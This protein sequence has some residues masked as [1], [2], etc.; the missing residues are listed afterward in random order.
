MRAIAGS[1]ATPVCSII[2]AVNGGVPPTAPERTGSGRG[3]RRV[4]PDGARA[5]A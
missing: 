1:A 3:L 5:G 2:D 4:R